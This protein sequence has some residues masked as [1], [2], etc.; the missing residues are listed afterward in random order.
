MSHNYAKRLINRTVA[1]MHTLLYNNLPRG[2]ANSL[3]H[4]LVVFP[5][6]IRRCK[7][8]LQKVLCLLTAHAHYGHMK[9]V[10]IAQQLLRNIS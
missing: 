8:I 7:Y 3:K 5:W 4:F 2:G 1:L 10:S 9:M 6:P